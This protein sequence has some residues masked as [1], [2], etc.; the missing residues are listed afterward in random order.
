MTTIK[1]NALP[2]AALVPTPPCLPRLGP[3][4]PAASP[5]RLPRHRAHRPLRRARLA[6]PAYPTAADEPHDAR[7]VRELLHS[8]GLHEGEYEPC[9]VHQFDDLAYRYVG[10]V[11]GDAQVYADHVGKAQLDVDDVCLAIQL[12]S[13]LL[14][15]TATALR[16]T[17]PT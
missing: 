12:E 17:N 1:S 16:G 8:M 10:D 5:T 11:L 4:R 14:F 3:A 9:V 2:T 15:P 6:Y 7:V 13:Q